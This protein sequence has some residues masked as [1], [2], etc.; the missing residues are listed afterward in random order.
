MGYNGFNRLVIPISGTVL[1][2]EYFLGFL[3][4]KL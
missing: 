3:E 4:V 2:M 1:I